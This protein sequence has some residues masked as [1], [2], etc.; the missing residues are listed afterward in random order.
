MRFIIKNSEFSMAQVNSK[1]STDA[2][3]QFGEAQRE[4]LAALQA[5]A[6]AWAEGDPEDPPSV[7]VLARVLEPFFQRKFLRRPF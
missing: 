1:L 3:P 5:A 4:A 2:G 7:E 6:D